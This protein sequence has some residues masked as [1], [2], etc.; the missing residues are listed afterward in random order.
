MTKWTTP[1][2]P[3][4]GPEGPFIHLASNILLNT[5]LRQYSSTQAY[6]LGLIILILCV[7]KLRER[8]GARPRSHSCAARLVGLLALRAHCVAGN[9]PGVALLWTQSRPF[10]L[11]PGRCCYYLG[12]PSSLVK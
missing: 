1:S 12:H 3:R 9:V 8:L 7:R 2:S 11:D 4:E 6:N 5:Y 10:S